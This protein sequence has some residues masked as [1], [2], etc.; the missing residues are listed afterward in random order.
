[1]TSGS[2]RVSRLERQLRRTADMLGTCW[3]LRRACWFVHWLQDWLG[4]VR[5]CSTNGVFFYSFTLCCDVVRWM[6]LENGPGNRGG[7]FAFCPRWRS[8]LICSE[9]SSCETVEKV[10]LPRSGSVLDG[11]L[12]RV[13]DLQS[14]CRGSQEA[15]ILL[16]KP[17]DVWIFLDSGFCWWMV[18]WSSM[19]YFMDCS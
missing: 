12:V 17:G 16:G 5:N 11:H 14:S 7:R 1:M 19:H 3:A 2:C 10:P 9:F 13:K 8:G 4:I 15:F 6:L 18:Y